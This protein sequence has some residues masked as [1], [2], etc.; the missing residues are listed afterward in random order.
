MQ[1]DLC[2]QCA[3]LFDPHSL[4]ATTGDPMDGGIMLC[5]EPGCVC[6]STWSMKPKTPPKL[7]PD[8]FQIEA[9]R[10]QIQA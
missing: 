1:P 10:E 8:R 3:H 9:I 2:D 5:P 4:V 6:Y 7:V